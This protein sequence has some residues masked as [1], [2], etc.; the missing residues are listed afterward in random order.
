MELAEKISGPLQTMMRIGADAEEIRDVLVRVAPAV[1][2]VEL[3]Q[4][5]QAR[6]RSLAGQWAAT[7]YRN[8]MTL[9]WPEPSGTG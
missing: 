7:P 6:L 2:S 5:L 1:A 9:E 4:R 3:A 8:E